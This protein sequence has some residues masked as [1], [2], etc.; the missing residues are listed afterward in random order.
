[1]SLYKIGLAAMAIATG[2]VA[3]TFVYAL[4]APTRPLIRSWTTTVIEEEP[5]GDWSARTTVA[6]GGPREIIILNGRR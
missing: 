6:S 4:N 5:A 1:M 2:C 3:A